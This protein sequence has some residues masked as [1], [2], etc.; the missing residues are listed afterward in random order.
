VSQKAEGWIALRDRYDDGGFS[1]GTLERP[2]LQRLL[3]DIDAGRVDVVVLYKIDRLS[4][5]LMD[6][7]KLV[8][9]FDRRSV[10]F[11][12]VTQSFNT[13]TSMGRLTL[14]VLLSFAQFEREVTGERIRD[15]IAASKRK[16]MWMG[17]NPP[18]GYHVAER[19]LVVSPAEAE[20]INLIFRRYLDLGCVRLLC[21]DLES[22][23]VLSKRRILASG[24]AVGGRVMGRSAV[25]AILKN[26][27]YVGEVTH[28]EKSYPGE[29]DA[30]VPRKLF[31]AVQARL[32]ELAPRITGKV[33]AEQDAP[34][35][36]L[37]FD[38]TGAAMLPTYSIK[39]GGIRYRYYTSRPARKGERSQAVIHRIPAPPFE[40]YLAGVLARVGLN[41]QKTL[42]AGHVVERINIMARSIDIEL[43]RDA[44]LDHWRSSASD[45]SQRDRAL[46]DT[47]HKQ[48]REG[49]TI[50][51]TGNR[52]LLTLPVRAKFRGGRA[53]LID[54]Q[55]TTP[56]AA[57]IDVAL[58]KAIARA[59]RFRQLLEDGEVTSVEALA[60]RF[61]L[62]RGHAGRTLNLAF[63]S[64][65]ITRAII[66][67]EQP[68][69]LLL[70]HLLH[71]DI[72]ASWR[73]QEEAIRRIAQRAST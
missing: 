42:N 50:T 23:H 17:G 72:P 66:C 30:I 60:R 40:A 29:H 19:K 73:L 52:L 67:G 58:I 18:L 38:E 43:R 26:R 37:L 36:G 32:A 54:V 9:A 6:F 62:D 47:A 64:P 11:V 15:K 24:K 8:E 34:F 12:S 63:L 31:D 4:R 27:A 61:D 28:K 25:Y 35:A 21:A 20:T 41:D 1:G 33:R 65:A 7:A 3:K 13:T 39:R 70:T 59:Y 57:H 55:D 45:G 49:E 71:A 14:N 69:G 44:T 56:S 53:S 22:R 16:G 51:D 68:P 46:L 5:S 48:L 2:A 10:T